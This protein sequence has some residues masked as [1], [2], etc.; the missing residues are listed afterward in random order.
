MKCRVNTKM[1]ILGPPF[2]SFQMIF[3]RSLFV[4]Y[5]RLCTFGR[6]IH[7]KA[8]EKKPE[9]QRMVGKK[10]IPLNPKLFYATGPRI[11]NYDN[12]ASQT[13][14]LHHVFLINLLETIIDLEYFL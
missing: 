8:K 9:T 12:E 10:K 13:C 5:A 4:S 2:P 3:A 11:C 14:Q 6:V 7:D 1:S